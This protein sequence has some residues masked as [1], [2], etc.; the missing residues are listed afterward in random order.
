MR[1]G[2]PRPH[3]TLTLSIEA[4][5]ALT[6]A[7]GSQAASLVPPSRGATLGRGPSGLQPRL[8]DWVSLSLME[9]VRVR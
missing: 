1:R 6:F 4:R 8:I 5:E 3:L 9:R 7:P 2:R